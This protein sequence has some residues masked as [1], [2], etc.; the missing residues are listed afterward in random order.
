MLSG[1]PIIV[2]DAY[3]EARTAYLGHLIRITIL[4]TN[5]LSQINILKILPL[6]LFLNL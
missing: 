2:V 3:L 1:R 5:V 4:C 6:H